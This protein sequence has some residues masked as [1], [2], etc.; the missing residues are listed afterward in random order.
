[1]YSWRESQWLLRQY[2][3]ADVKTTLPL[4]LSLDREGGTMGRV[5]LSESDAEL[6][7]QFSSYTWD[8]MVNLSFSECGIFT[9]IRRIL[10]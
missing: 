8:E 10:R 2:G 1:M 7:Y 4:G 9:D 5:T 6:F 3:G